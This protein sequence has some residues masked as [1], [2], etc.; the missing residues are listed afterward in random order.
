M[1]TTEPGFYAVR[2]RALK[3]EGVTGKRA[4]VTLRAGR[5]GIVGEEGGA[6]WIDPADIAA[7]RVGYDESKYGKH[8]HTHI[9]RSSRPQPLSLYPAVR[10]GSPLRRHHPRPGGGRRAD[11]RHRPHRARNVGLRGL[12][13]AGADGAGVPRRSCHRDFRARRS[14]LVAA[15][16]ARAAGRHRCLLCCCGT[17][18]RGW[19]RV[20]SRSSASWTG[21]CLSRPSQE[22]GHLVQAPLHR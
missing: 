7:M 16:H 19:R 18:R 12:A 8:F 5:L 21:S 11:R 15:L 13:G 9:V 20:R 4:A 6:I 10:Q 3:R 17:P 22:S 14:C 2:T 1:S